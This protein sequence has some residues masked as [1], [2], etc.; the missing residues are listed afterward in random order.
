M[1]TKSAG[2]PAPPILVSGPKANR[3]NLASAFGFSMK[4]FI[5]SGSELLI[6]RVPVARIRAGDIITYL[7]PSGASVTHRVVK[8]LKKGTEVLFLTKGDNRFAPDPLVRENQ[9]LGRV[10]R[11][12]GTNIRAFF[13][14]WAGRGIAAA[15]YTAYRVVETL[16]KT[17][18][19]RLRH[20]LEHRGHL[21]KVKLRSLSESLVNPLRWVNV[22]SSGAGG[23]KWGWSKFRL[24]SRGFRVDRTSSASAESMVGIWNQA[25]PEYAADSG[26]FRRLVKTGSFFL[27]HRGSHLLGWAAVRIEASAGHIDIVALNEEVRNQGL[28]R[29]LFYEIIRWFKKKKVGPILLNPHP[30]PKHSDGIPAIP[31]LV[32]ASGFGFEP[33]ESSIEWKLTQGD[34]VFPSARASETFAVREIQE[35]DDRAVKDFF[36]RNDRAVPEPYRFSGE[37]VLIALRGNAI[38]GFCRFVSE[39]LLHSCGAITWAWALSKP[40]QKRGYLVR[41]LVDRRHQREGIGTCLSD[42]AF[43]S[44][45]EAGC[46]EIRVVALK[47]GVTDRFY[48]RF[49]FVENGCFLQLRRR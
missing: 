43:Q 4:P 49:G 30:I 37:K 2:D 12:D 23:V 3:L 29:T 21:P 11:V 46:R 47:D 20:A 31:L 15:S 27:I 22:V 44:L 45:F 25:F 34:Y 1:T 36:E 38:V 8:V 28:D 13:W 5:R 18:A 35:S 26:R 19:N 42:K 41:L 14:L 16:S 39:D 48:K 10:T 33:A 7:S 24:A 6:E 17:P 40:S 32:T 9:V